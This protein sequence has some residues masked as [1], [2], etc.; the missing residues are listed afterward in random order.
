[1]TTKPSILKPGSIRVDR[2]YD[3]PRERLW[4]AIA[5]R[6]HLS[7]W[8]TPCDF[9]PMAGHAFTFRTDP[10]PGFDGVIHCV[11]EEPIPG[12]RLVFCGREAP[13]T[14]G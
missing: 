1:M 3:H 4:R 12:E 11:V 6:E 10:G 2:V 5:I 13:W 9:A 14:R 7:R 8:P